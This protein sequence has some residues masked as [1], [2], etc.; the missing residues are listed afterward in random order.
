PSTIDSQISQTRLVTNGAN[1]LKAEI[2]EECKTETEP[3]HSNPKVASALKRINESRKAFLPEEKKVRGVAKPAPPKSYP[4]NLVTRNTPPAPPQPKAVPRPVVSQSPKPTLIPT[5]RIEKKYD[6]NK[7][8]RI[9]EEPAADK[10]EELPAIE[11]PET[12]VSEPKV[13]ISI[14]ITKS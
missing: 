12:P 3:A 11:K 9:A 13:E 7:L 14:R 6:T 10:S 8:P 1:A 5:F 2:V 4:F